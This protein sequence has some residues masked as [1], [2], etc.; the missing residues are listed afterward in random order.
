MAIAILQAKCNIMSKKIL[1]VDDNEFIVEI[2]T[3][4]LHNKGYEVIA[5]HDGVK[6]IDHIKTDNPDLVILDVMLP[7]A[8]GRDLCKEIKLNI[9]TRNLPVIICT[10][11]DDLKLLMNQ[12]GCPDDVLYK[13]FDIDRLVNMVA[14]QLAA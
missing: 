11:S 5:L 7:S 14:Y 10:G 6:V 2:M 1:I 4:I 13:P 9:A 3:Y 8:D 12:P